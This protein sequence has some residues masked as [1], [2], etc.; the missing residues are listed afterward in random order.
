MVFL[1]KTIWFN[2]EIGR[3]FGVRPIFVQNLSKFDFLRSKFVKMLGSDQI[4]AKFWFFK[5]K[6]LVIKSKLVKMLWFDDKCSQIY[7][8]EVENSPKL[9]FQIKI[10][11]LLVRKKKNHFQ[12]E[13]GRSSKR[14]TCL[15]DGNQAAGAC[16]EADRFHVCTGYHRPYRYSW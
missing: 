11:Q 13:R 3:N 10:S 14:L 7:V 16:Y 5:V 12:C 1:R 15:D 2:V 4:F 8:S 9:D 6:N